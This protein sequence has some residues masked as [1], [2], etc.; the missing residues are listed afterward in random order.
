MIKWVHV[1]DNS[2]NT[3]GFKSNWT[4]AVRVEKTNIFKF[5]NIPSKSTGK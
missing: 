1:K 5:N 2:E 4:S 3:T